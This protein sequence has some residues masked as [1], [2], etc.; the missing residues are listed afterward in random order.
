[1]STMTDLLGTTAQILAYRLVAEQV[2]L[3][4]RDAPVSPPTY[5]LSDKEKAAGASKFAL[6]QGVAIPQ[7]RDAA[8]LGEVTDQDNTGIAV[9]IDSLA[10]RSHAMNEVMQARVEQV[11]GRRAPGIY[12][13]APDEDTVATTAAQMWKSNKAKLTSSGVDQEWF[14]REV[15]RAVADTYAGGR[16]STWSASHRHADAVIRYANDPETGKQIW[17]GGPLGDLIRQTS[18]SGGNELISMFPGSALSGFWLSARSPR[19][20]K[21]ARSLTAEVI[22]Y[23]AVPHRR[24]AIKGDLLG[25]VPADQVK[26]TMS[27]G[28]V[29]ATTGTPGK[30]ERPSELGFGQIPGEVEDVA[31]ICQTILLRGVLSAQSLRSLIRAD[32]EHLDLIEA[33][34]VL[35]LLDSLS[36]GFRRSGADF[37]TGARRLTVICADGTETDLSVEAVITAAEQVLAQHADLLAQARQ[38]EASAVQVKL[39]AA[40]VAKGFVN[41]GDD[42]DSGDA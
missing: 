20:E 33:I 30:K 28:E 2:P 41:G 15:A 19:I 17:A 4:G 37:V 11:L 40:R 21:L 26:M 6:S 27:A 29:D 39:I 23:G 14:I 35:G 18:A 8:T 32:T 10:A 22:G 24:A 16:V 34:G 25:G 3:A 5:M 36:A 1:M 12:V 42:S 38:A 7:G 31:V 9:I 13:E